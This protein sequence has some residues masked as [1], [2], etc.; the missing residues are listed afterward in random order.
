[1]RRLSNGVTGRVNM[2]TLSE[3]K[4]LVDRV[5][6][7]ADGEERF[8]ALADAIDGLVFTCNAEG[9]CTFVNAALS[10]FMGLETERCL[11]RGWLDPVHEEDR[12]RIRDRFAAADALKQP[13]VDELRVCGHDGEFRWLEMKARPTFDR[14]GGFVSWVGTMLVRDEI[15]GT[16]DVL[17]A[18]R[19][20]RDLRDGVQLEIAE[21]LRDVLWV[22]EVGASHFLYINAAYERIWGRCRAAVY[23]DRFDTLNWVHPEDRERVRAALHRQIEGTYDEE[24]RIVRPDGTV[25]WLREKA[26]PIRDATGNVT[27]LFGVAEDITE[28]RE[29]ETQ[30]RAAQKMESI[31]QLAG[32]IAHDFNNLLTI[33]VACNEELLEELRDTASVREPLLE[34]RLAVQRATSLTRDLLAFSRRR[35]HE[36]KVTDLNEVVAEAERMLR[37]LIGEDV[38]LTTTLGGR[39][40]CVRIDPSQFTSVLV[41]LAVN[42]RHAM[43]RGG[44]LSLRTFDLP[45]GERLPELDLRRAVHLGVTLSDV[46]HVVLEVS[47]EGMGFGHE[48]GERIFEPFFTTKS[49]GKGTGLGLAVVHGIVKQSGGHIEVA[50]APGIG[51]TFRIYLPA[52]REISVTPR[53]LVNADLRGTET[54]LLVED[55]SA[56]RRAAARGLEARGFRVLPAGDAEE[57]LRI[58]EELRGAIDILVT[59]VVLPKM[60]GRSLVERVAAR[61]PA[62]KILYTSG[63][64]SDDVSR[65]GLTLAEVSFL[66]KP[67]TPQRLIGRMRQLLDAPAEDAAARTGSDSA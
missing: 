20:R 23:R 21:N 44:S 53:D 30:L 61:F 32:G 65:Y 50:S 8:R 14:F 19:E 13:F 27:Q 31:G 39:V 26:S 54:V 64:A 58:I 37:R 45:A 9:S 51:T 43:P 47:D 48:I 16:D 11:G 46:R 55:E 67:Y 17:T 12:P 15:F 56:V 52:V 24:Y 36:P 66:A 34:T 5:D 6:R 2:W 7:A 42:A 33:I 4:I 49:A 18:I 29:L 22:Y 41:N 38:D 63:Y 59:D 35:H 40:P 57:A 62:I 1:M 10:A 3:T 25:R 60:D 28:R